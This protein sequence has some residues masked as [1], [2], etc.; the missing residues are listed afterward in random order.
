LEWADS[1]NLSEN[2]LDR[3]LKTGDRAKRKMIE[4]NLRL[5]VAIAKKY[6]KRNME[7]LD[8]IQEGSLGL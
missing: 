8:L 1:V 2:E 3:A 5:V 7:F 4:A 6:Q